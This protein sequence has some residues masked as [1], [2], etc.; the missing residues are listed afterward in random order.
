MMKKKH[1]NS[2]MSISAST[3]ISVFPSRDMF[4]RSRNS[5]ELSHY[6]FEDGIS[7]VEVKTSERQ[8]Q[9]HLEELD[10]NAL[11]TVREYD[12]VDYLAATLRAEEVFMCVNCYESIPINQVDHH[13][14]IC[15]N[16]E[17][18]LDKIMDKVHKLVFTIREYKLDADLRHEYAL[19]QLEEIGKSMCEGTSVSFI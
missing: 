11:N 9:I 1:Q 4:S 8:E 10:E 2:L 17:T 6:L 16:P 18:D 12:D 15:C 3:S 7:S 13:S 5:G 19:I 14:I